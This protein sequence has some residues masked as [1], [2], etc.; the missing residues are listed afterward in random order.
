MVCMGEL[1]C[2]LIVLVVQPLIVCMWESIERR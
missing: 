1:D 2:E